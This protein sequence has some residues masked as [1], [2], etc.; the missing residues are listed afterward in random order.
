MRLEDLKPI[1]LLFAWIAAI[2]NCQRKLKSEQI[3]GIAEKVLAEF[4]MGEE[5]ER[6][7]LEK[8]ISAYV[9][10]NNLG[11]NK[12]ELYKKYALVCLNPKNIIYVK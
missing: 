6:H 1:A 9:K 5:L 3:V 2:K 8:A 10:I 4:S 11:H 7:T 12:E